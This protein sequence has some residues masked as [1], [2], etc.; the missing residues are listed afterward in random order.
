[1]ILKS[2]DLNK[3]QRKDLNQSGGQSLKISNLALSY[4]S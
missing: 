1:M 2:S 4:L 3:L